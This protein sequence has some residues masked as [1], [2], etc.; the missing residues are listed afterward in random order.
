VVVG[1]APTPRSSVGGGGANGTSNGGGGGADGNTTSGGGG[2]SQQQQHLL[3]HRRLVVRRGTGGGPSSHGGGNG[4]YSGGGGGSSLGSSLSL[5]ARA[6]QRLQQQLASS[7][8]LLRRLPTPTLGALCLAAVASLVL[9]AIGYGFSATASSSSAEEGRAAAGVAAVLGAYLSSSSSSSSSGWAKSG[10]RLPSLSF[11]NGGAGAIIREDMLPPVPE[12]CLAAVTTAAASGRHA[13]RQQQQELRRSIAFGVASS[14]YQIEGAWQLGDKGSSIWDAFVHDH[15][16]RGEEGQQQQQQQ[17][18]A[19][20]GND[21][22]TPTA[23]PNNPSDTGDVASDHYLHWR[24]DVLLLKRL[25]VKHYRLSVSW[26]RVLPLGGRGSPV[27][28]SGLSHYRALVR[29]LIRAGITPVVTLYHWDLPQALQEAYGGFLDVQFADDFAHYADLVFGA[30]QPL[31]VKHWITFSEPLSICQLG[32]GIGTAAPGVARGS[33]GQYLCGHHLLVAHARAVQLFR[34][35]YGAGVGGGGSGSGDGGGRIG[36]AVSGHWPLPRDVHSLADAAASRAYLEHTVGWI[37]D[38]LYTGDYP[39]SMRKSQGPLL[40]AFSAADARLLN[41]SADFFALTYYTSHFVAAP[42]PGGPRSQ[43]FEEHLKDSQGRLP[44]APSEVPWL[45]STPAGLRHM[46]GW[47]S[48]RYGRPEIWIAENGYCEPGEG[49]LPAHEALVDARRL[50]YHLSH[51]QAACEAAAEDGARVA[52]YFAWSFLDGFEGSD[53][54][55]PRFGLVRVDRNTLERAPK[56]SAHWMARHFFGD[57]GAAAIPC[58]GDGGGGGCGG[59]GGGDGGGGSKAR[60]RRSSWLPGG[61]AAA[62]V[63]AVDW[64]GAL[65]E[66]MLGGGVG[67]GGG[68][69]G[70]GTGARAWRLLSRRR[71]RE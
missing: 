70:G 5:A 33:A 31:G 52:A 24:D 29:E 38:P 61:K 20:D 47:V 21:S 37:A 35:R 64:A 36:L 23:A 46:L 12:A 2:S 63:A 51:L 8:R 48:R 4:P 3:H 41:G 44:G 42:P 27:S 6:R 11:S 59:G 55:R 26:P 32:Y 65:E 57:N 17:Q 60:R 16:R 62:A 67:G 53:G 49:E 22:A 28:A 9:A 71:R 40:P 34:Q 15:E 50:G 69:G 14:A 43:L 66:G 18:A 30:L 1:I 10:R 58:L 19:A 25:G 13:K 45:F 54:Y 7:L 39:R 68:D 56:L